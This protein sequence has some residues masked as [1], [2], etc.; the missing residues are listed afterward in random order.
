MTIREVF[1][2]SVNIIKVWPYWKDGC[3]KSD[4][5]A[6]ARDGFCQY[7]AGIA[8]GE[9]GIGNRKPQIHRL[10]KAI[11]CLAHYPA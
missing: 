2:N 10:R 9:I 6:I 5:E 8:V 7:Q 4:F 3:N 1:R 11:L